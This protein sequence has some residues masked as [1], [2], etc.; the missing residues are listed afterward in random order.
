MRRVIVALAIAAAAVLAGAASPASA[1]N[2][3]V[4]SD[5]AAGS[6]VTEQPGTITVT[7]ND[8][9]LNLDNGSGFAMLVQDAAGRYYGDGCVTVKGASIAMD[10]QLGSPGDYTVTWQVVSTDSHSA[11][12]SFTFHWA[13]AAGEQLASG[14]TAAPDCGGTAAAP[15]GTVAGADGGD[16]STVWW[17]VGG[18][19][20]VIVAI[21]ATLVILRP[22]K[23]D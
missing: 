13:P 14:S 23:R 6:T 21:I 11:S 1:H 15:S 7:T 17:I 2:Y 16:D 19:G 20:V 3:L 4:G 5:P 12:D 22:R 18:V 9:L 10:A 8:V